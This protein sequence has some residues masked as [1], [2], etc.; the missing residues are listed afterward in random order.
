MEYTIGKIETLLLMPK[1]V[2]DVDWQEQVTRVFSFLAYLSLP[3]VI[4]VL[5]IAIIIV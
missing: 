2:F 4:L 5:F 1:E 3:A